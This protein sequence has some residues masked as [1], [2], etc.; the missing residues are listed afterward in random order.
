MF[1]ALGITRSPLSKLIEESDTKLTGKKAAIL[2]KQLATIKCDIKELNS[3]ALDS[4][5]LEINE[6]AMRNIFQE[7]GFTS[8]IK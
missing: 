2:C 6:E 4:L 7:L 1:K 8:L 3:V 5:K